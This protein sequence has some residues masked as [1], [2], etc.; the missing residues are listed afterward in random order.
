MRLKLVIVASMLAAILGAG[1][2]IVIVFLAFASFKPFTN[3]GL[4]VLS[5]FLLP[6]ASTI[7]AAI[8][9]YRHT[10]RRRKLQAA[11]TVLIATLITLCLLVVASIVSA[12]RD[13]IEPPQPV[14]PRIAS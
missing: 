6:A 1:S 8:F 14:G 13:K 3:P 4:L 11:L 5:T 10:A 2:C 7:F 12:R 9:V